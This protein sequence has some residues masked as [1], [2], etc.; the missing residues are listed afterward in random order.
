ME[1]YH[2]M[3]AEGEWGADIRTVS[4]RSEFVHREE[5]RRAVP[6]NQHLREMSLRGMRSVLV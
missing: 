6:S 1:L 3:I 4:S 5:P 2:V